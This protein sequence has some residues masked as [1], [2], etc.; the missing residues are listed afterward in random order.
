[1]PR[2]ANGHRDIGA[3]ERQYPEDV[4]FRSGFDSS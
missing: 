1:L 4:I 3:V 2:S